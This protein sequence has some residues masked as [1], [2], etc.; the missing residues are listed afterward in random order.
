MQCLGYGE[1]DLENMRAH[2][3]TPSLSSLTLR[4]QHDRPWKMN[5]SQDA[6]SSPDTMRMKHKS[7]RLKIRETHNSVIKLSVRG[8]ETALQPSPN[9][10]CP[11]VCFLKC[12][13]V[14]P[15]VQ[16]RGVRRM[17]NAT[18]RKFQGSIC[19]P[20]VP[21]FWNKIERQTKR[22]DLTFKKKVAGASRD[23]SAGKS[24][25]CFRG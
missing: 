14:S 8:S 19:C 22:A 20:T 23:A 5:S 24:L 17:L 13:S 16:D 15:F 11:L 9:F 1:G 4:P 2:P 7:F 6:S 3:A 18:R 12:S 25:K 21:S 10:F